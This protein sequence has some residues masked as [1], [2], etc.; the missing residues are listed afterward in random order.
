M[1][2]KNS[3][4]SYSYL[5]QLSPAEVFQLL[6]KAAKKHRGQYL[7]RVHIVFTGGMPFKFV[8]LEVPDPY[9][10]KNWESQAEKETF[11]ELVEAFKEMTGRQERHTFPGGD[12]RGILEGIAWLLLKSANETDEKIA[13]GKGDQYLVVTRA[14][15]EKQ[16][17]L[18]FKNLC[19]HATSTRVSSF[20]IDP[21]KGAGSRYL[22]HLK[23]DSRRKSSFSS[24]AASG[25][26]NE[27]PCQVLKGFE[28]EEHVTF[29]PREAQP[30]ERKLHYF[31]RLVEAA[32]VLFGSKEYKN[33][34]G[35]TAAVLQWPGPPGTLEK[36]GPETGDEMELEFFYLGE[37]RFFR[38]E[39]FTKRKVDRAQFEYMHLKESQK[40]LDGLAAA[41]QKAKPYVG[42][43]LELQ[44][45]KFLEKNQLERLLDQKARIEHNIAYLQSITVPQP[46]LMRFTQEQLPALA[47]QIRSFPMHIIH[48]G[49]LKYGF[50]AFDNEPAGYHFILIDLRETGRNELDPLPLWQDLNIDVLHMRFRLD[51]FWAYHYYEAGGD[52][53]VFVPGGCAL[54]PPIHDWERGNMDQSLREIIGHWFHQRLKGQAIPARP[55]YL[56]DG[57]PGKKSPIHISVLDQDRME[58]L[59]TRLGWINDNL[60][61]NQALEKESLMK[62]MA[63][64]ITWGE[65]AQKIK[66]NTE[67]TRRDFSEAALAASQHTAKTTN[68][69]TRVLTTAIDRVV[70]ETFRMTQKIRRMNQ[71]LQEWDK[72]L[73]D[74]DEMLQEVRGQKQE[75]THRMGASKNEFWRME[76]QIQKEIQ[77]SERRRKE[78]EGKIVEE[79]Q[80]LQTATRRLKLR[81]KSLKL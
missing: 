75:T 17:E 78:L 63:K 74:M 14:V 49:R 9:G 29:L 59:H 58:P 24:L 69:M 81:L 12:T 72:M 57:A 19:F 73:A 47:A 27:H 51:P 66:I 2:N 60:L 1:N 34:T 37:L 52:S 36:P 67:K 55:I 35:L 43:R 54:F 4:Y 80:K 48:D 46:V 71:R 22:F 21:A 68:E 64:D 62:E 61:I 6:V 45:T 41:I 23:D 33:S 40:A 65:L 28:T 44:G 39:L 16:A 11:A 42:Y 25:L 38:E 13:S 70:K 32:P 15:D 56:F 10:D 76:Q 5:D 7:D 8:D 18:L 26:F 3:S 31:C 30:G 50:Q 79:V 20:D 53:M 77:A